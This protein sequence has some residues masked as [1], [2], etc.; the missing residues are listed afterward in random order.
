[1]SLTPKNKAKGSISALKNLAK[2]LSIDLAELEKARKMPLDAR[3]ERKEVPK[4][5]GGHR[6][7]YNPAPLIRKIQ[8]R[9]NQRIFK[10]LVE[11]PDY[12]FGSL[13]NET[14]KNL[15]HETTS[16]IRRDY[17]ACAEKHCGAKS[18]FKLDIANYFES[19][20]RDFVDEIFKN[21]FNFSNDV[22]DYLTEICCYDDKLIQGAI[23]SS[24]L[25]S[26]CLWDVEGEVV[27]K[28]A[29]K[30]LTYT[31]LVDD[32]TVSSQTKNHDYA[33]V[34][35]YIKGMLL[36]KDLPLNPKKIKIQRSGIEPLMVHGLRVDFPSPRLPAK[37]IAKIRASVH[38]VTSM[39]RVNNYRTSNSYRK[40]YDRCM[41]R[42][43]KLARVGHNKHKTLLKK[44]LKNKPLP[45][46]Q[47]IDKVNRAIKRLKKLS[48]VDHSTYRYRRL[49]GITAYR[50]TI[51]KR[52]HKR[53]AEEF[54]NELSTLNKP[55]E[56]HKISS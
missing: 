51:I 23:T 45:S 44:L 3:Y 6:Q 18:V 20:H 48:Q 25:A 39:A 31:R 40:Q 54:L 35:A 10:E 2:A 9:I 27:K 33:H 15:G 12:L 19:I 13:P 4:A 34:E 36:A 37:E 41:G 30:R 55:I 8:N 43:N 26:L 14:R 28:I 49:F 24:Y 38:N 46:Q 56:K 5:G 50:V 1:M 17:I 52:T 11:W 53:E 29:R 42:V 21:F 7:V 16:K 22:S 32:I 47:D